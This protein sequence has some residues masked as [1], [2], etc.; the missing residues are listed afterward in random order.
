MGVGFLV[1]VGVDSGLSFISLFVFV[2]R[3]LGFTLF[4][5]VAVVVIFVLI[6]VDVLALLTAACA[7]GVAFIGVI[8]LYVCAL[9]A[10]IVD[11]L[12]VVSLSIRC[13]DCRTAIFFSVLL[14]F[15]ICIFLCRHVLWVVVRCVRSLIWVCRSSYSS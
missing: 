4:V 8:G 6:G 1:W 15:L 12:A 2:V 9:L 7:I 11:I 10:V 13:F 3:L 14:L 5:S